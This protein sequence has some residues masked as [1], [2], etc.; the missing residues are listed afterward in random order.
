VAVSR[1]DSHGN[2]RAVGDR[3]A[4]VLHLGTNT[5]ILDALAALIR[6]L[7]V[8]VENEAVECA[9]LWI[10]GDGV[11]GI[12]I[13]VLPCDPARCGV[14]GPPPL[15]LMVTPI[16]AGENRVLRCLPTHLSSTEIASLLGLSRHTVKSHTRSI[17]LKL[18]VS[19]RDA[20]VRRARELG[21]LG[22]ASGS[23]DPDA[24]ESVQPRLICVAKR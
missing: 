17:Y 14:G 15:T 4:Q 20:A 5:E 2:G 9:D 1:M 24:C 7:Q 8:N 13:A 16:T 10:V 22:T 12:R 3:D 6:P 11:T 18:E 21:I 23:D 19:S